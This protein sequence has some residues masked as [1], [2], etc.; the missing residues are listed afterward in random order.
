MVDLN[1]VAV[2]PKKPKG[3]FCVYEKI[4]LVGGMIPTSS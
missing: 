4:C 1:L 3:K 2:P